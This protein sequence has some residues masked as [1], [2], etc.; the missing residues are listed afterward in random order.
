MEEDTAPDPQADQPD[1]QA[2]LSYKEAAVAS[3]LN[4]D[5]DPS[6]A[7]QGGRS[8]DTSST[9][10]EVLDDLADFLKPSK[11][12]HDPLYSILLVNH[13]DKTPSP[14]DS[15]VTK[16]VHAAIETARRAH[17]AGPHIEASAFEFT[18]VN[19]ISSAEKPKLGWQAR[20]GIVAAPATGTDTDAH[21]PQLYREQHHEYI[22]QHSGKYNPSQC[23]VNDLGQCVVKASEKAHPD[24]PVD[25]E[26]HHFLLS[27]SYSY[28]QTVN[29]P[30]E[31]AQGILIGL[32]PDGTIHQTNRPSCN[33][34]SQF[35]QRTLK[36]YAKTP[37]AV[38]M[39]E[40]EYTFNN[41]IGFR[42]AKL[43]APKYTRHAPGRRQTPIFYVQAANLPAFQTL[44]GA[45][46][47]C[48][49]SLSYNGLK[50]RI[51]GFPP[52]APNRGMPTRT[53]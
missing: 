21:N 11:S 49:N 37:E 44:L 38:A 12:N 1:L 29:A 17:A 30:Q 33:D 28:L 13:T 41:Y 53:K 42:A 39:L 25:E 26:H 51:E 50:L 5:S 9:E 14:P 35:M 48:P 23:F 31:S 43:D 52:P 46:R 7:A 47:N 45:I 19:Y 27:N 18:Q 32:V 10:V 40:D 3:Q 34:I 36:P 4:D 8:E 24:P 2:R 16:E 20:F 22:I 6:D 15:K